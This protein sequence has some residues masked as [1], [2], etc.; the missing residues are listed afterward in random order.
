MATSTDLLTHFGGTA[1]NSLTNII[2]NNNNNNNINIGDPELDSFK[3]VYYLQ[4]HISEFTILSLNVQSLHAKID[5]LKILI[6]DLAQHN[7]YFNIICVQETWL[8]QDFNVDLIQL[9]HYTFIYK[10]KTSSEHGGVGFYIYKDFAFTSLPLL[11]NSEI[12]DGIFVDISSKN[13]I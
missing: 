3:L 4:K 10:A 9:E 2:I 11:D 12:C 7:L 13:I 5:Q 1:K 8:S 6:Y